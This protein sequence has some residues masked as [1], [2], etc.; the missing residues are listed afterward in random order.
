MEQTLVILKPDAVERRLV[1]EIVTRFEK[2]GFRITAMRMQTIAPELARRH[3]AA[4]VERPFYPELE[5]YITRGPVFVMVL[6]GPGVIESVRLMLGK[7]NGLEA[8]PGSIRGDY[9]TE[10]T[11]NLVHASDGPESARQEI[12]NFFPEPVTP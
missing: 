5:A 10:T 3:Y 7:T 8:E 12:A 11:Q 6:E 2:K 9:A 1:G 4:H